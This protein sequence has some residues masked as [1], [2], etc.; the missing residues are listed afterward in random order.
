MG[1]FIL[2]ALAGWGISK[3]FGGG[4]DKQTPNTQVGSLSTEPLE[5]DSLTQYMR[6]LT[7]LLGTSGES[8]TGAGK[9]ILGKGLKTMDTGLTTLQGPLDYWTKI[10]GGDTGY[11]SS[12][13]SSSPEYKATSAQYAG[14]ERSAAT[15]LPRGGFR[16]TTLAGL[17]FEKAGKVSDMFQALRPQAAQAVAGIGQTQAQIGQGQ[18]ALGTAEQGLGI[19]QIMGALQG[20]LQRRGQN[21]QQDVATMSAIGEGI[22]S[23][24]SA[25]ISMG[26]KGK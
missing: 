3:L 25:L 6:S 5:G 2:P 10:L 15:S 18:A 4:D 14:A 9:D 21:T 16:S 23:I 17:P 12:L 8:M 1:A 26:G 22:G 24:L 13:V 19:E 20:L 7:N 11:T